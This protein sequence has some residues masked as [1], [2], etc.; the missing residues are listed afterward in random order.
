MTSQTAIQQELDKLRKE[1]ATELAIEKQL[2]AQERINAMAKQYRGVDEVVNIQDLIESV[3]NKTIA[4][5]IPCGVPEL[6][7][8]FGGFRPG[9]LISIIGHSASGKTTYAMQLTQSMLDQNPL[10]LSYEM[11]PEELVGLFLERQME[12]PRVFSPATNKRDD[13]KWIEQR[14][15]EAIAKY[16]C[17]IVYIDNLNW[18]VE[19]GN[20]NYFQRQEGAVNFLKEL[21]T[22]LRIP[23]VLL[24]HTSKTEDITEVPSTKMISGSKAIEAVSSE[25]I[26]VWREAYKDL[27]TREIVK[28][29]FALVKVLKNRRYG[30]EPTIEY[31]FNTSTYRYENK[32][33][34]SDFD[35]F[36]KGIS[37]EDADY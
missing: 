9:N 34:R 18:I 31:E 6:D 21:A 27:K 28:T 4:Q 36:G 2:E 14:I 11:P 12:V 26:A 15:R 5:P 17:R 13:H 33:W 3:K 24:V 37:D 25:I 22:T 7:E 16:D 8:A 10:W 35:T 1:I 23:I 32:I 19:P 20:D 30:V 29:N